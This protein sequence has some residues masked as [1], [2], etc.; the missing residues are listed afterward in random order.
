LPGEVS[1]GPRLV[2]EMAQATLRFVVSVPSLT[3]I[4]EL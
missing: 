1:T 2:F 3:L 4:T